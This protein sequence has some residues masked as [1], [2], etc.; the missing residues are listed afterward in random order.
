MK[1]SIE[2]I[3]HV[4]HAEI[5]VNSITVIAG[6]NNTGKSTVGKALYATA[7]GLNLLDTARVWFD[8]V[9]SVTT[10]INALQSLVELN[11]SQY[12]EFE[13]LKNSN[14]ITNYLGK[15]IHKSSSSIEELDR[16]YS[17]DMVIQINKFFKVFD[18]K[19]DKNRMRILGTL[20]ADIIKI[21]ET[22]INNHNFKINI[23]QKVF[24][25]EFFQQISHLNDVSSL[26][27]ICVKE[28]NQPQIN[29]IFKE[30]QIINEG[31][32]LDVHRPFSNAFYIDNPFI[33]DEMHLNRFSSSRK[34]QYNHSET[35]KETLNPKWGWE[36][37]NLFELINFES[38]IEEIFKYVMREGR[39]LEKKGRNYFESAD[40]KSP[41][42]IENLS[43][44][45]KAFS[46]LYMLLTSK[47][48]EECEYIILDEPEIHLHPDWQLKYAELIVLMSKKLNMKIIITSHSPYFIEAIEV[49]SKKHKY[50][51]GVKFYKTQLI[52]GKERYTLIDTTNNVSDL[53]D[54]L[55][56]ALYVLEDI[57]DSI[58]DGELNDDDC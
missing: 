39:F 9:E 40:M 23:M 16:E 3:G 55:A 18:L 26:S 4:K 29:I 37:Q 51:S 5:E 46:I 53:Y 56:A 19:E 32:K 17:K 57:R 34:S 24:E 38:K 44:G 41:L 12:M 14:S 25:E 45:M 10:K 48:L 22:P 35:L 15:F 43:T 2:N 20:Q 49:F 11:S 21:L 1:I 30:H 27:K 31:T 52:E 50:Y 58:E 54:D 8:K 36:K 33:L 13:E 47:G 6:N 28:L 7:T 42:L